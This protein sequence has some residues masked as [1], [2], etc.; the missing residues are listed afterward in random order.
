MTVTDQYGYEITLSDPDAL[1]SWHA[2]NRAFL[3]HGADTPAHIGKTLELAPDFA[4]GHAAHGL[5]CLLLGR[6]ELVTSAEKDWRLADQGR[7]AKGVTEREAAIVDALRDWLDG[8]PTRAASRLDAALAAHPA[9]AL[10]L[11]LI[12]AIRF[13][14]GDAAGMRSSIERVIGSY[15]PDHIAAG[16]VHGCHAFALEETGDYAA[17]E[18][19]G[20]MAVEMAP[21]D[22]WGLHAVAHVLDMT[23]RFDDGRIWLET[24]SNGWAHCNNFRYHCW[25]HLALMHLDRRDFDK[26]L[27][28]YDQEIRRDQTDDYRD[29]SNGASLLVR[30]EIEGVNV[31]GRWEELARISER[32]VDDSC[33]VFAD[34]HYLMSLN[35]GNRRV[36]AERLVENIE[37]MGEGASDMAEVARV[38]GVPAALGLDAY[39]RGNYFSAFHH[40]DRARPT[41]KTIGGSH[42]QRDVF[43]RLTVDA[44]LK[45]GLAGDAE[46]VLKERLA[47]RTAMDR[48]AEDRLKLVERMHEASRIMQDERLRAAHA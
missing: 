4:M 8:Y 24:N 34:L 30:L 2:T 31:G 19:I 18:R 32:R 39:R 22:A 48:F 33:N 5:F 26:V 41:L 23:G 43:E 45:A 6:R 21:D 10:L 14:L 11:K 9:D 13:V 46:R 37:T 40:L 1:G 7:R 12:H 29:I 27:A 16:Y 15:G 28:L 44:A 20:R 17:A 36:A 47:L 42:A 35:G 38:A 25:W 3:A